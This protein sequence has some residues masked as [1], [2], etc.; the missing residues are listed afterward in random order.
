M[1]EMGTWVGTKQVYGKKSSEINAYWRSRSPPNSY[2]NLL[3]LLY[4]IFVSTIF[5]T[6]IPT[7]RA[8]HP[9][10]CGSMI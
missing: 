6:L 9:S 7:L 4:I 1:R 2:S 8:H 5:P 3:E 10:F